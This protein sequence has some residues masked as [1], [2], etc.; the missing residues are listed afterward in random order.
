MKQMTSEEKQKIVD[1]LH[2]K[3]ANRPCPRCDEKNFTLLDGYFNQSIQQSLTAGVIL[4]GPSIPSIVILCNN[5]GYM[6]QHAL[7]VLGLIPKNKDNK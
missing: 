6:S 3:R 1:A 4:G 5:C 2:K 7:G